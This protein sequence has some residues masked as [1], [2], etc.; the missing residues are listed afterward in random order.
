[1]NITIKTIDKAADQIRGALQ[2]YRTQIDEAF[3]KADT[4]QFTVSLGVTFR[5][6]DGVLKIT[7]PIKFVSEQIKD[8]FETMY[9]P[10]QEELFSALASGQVKIS[11]DE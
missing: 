8:S 7:T 1:M 11:A 5:V 10:N 2:A 3:L 6:V 9:D 4:D